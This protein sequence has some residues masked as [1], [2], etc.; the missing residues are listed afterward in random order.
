MWNSSST[1]LILTGS[2]V[3]IIIDLKSFLLGRNPMK[4]YCSGINLLFLKD[5][6]SMDNPNGNDINKH[7][8]SIKIHTSTT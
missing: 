1:T 3:Y 6:G 5:R 4:C 2:F 7:T 8:Q